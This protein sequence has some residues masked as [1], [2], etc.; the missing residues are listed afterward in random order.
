MITRSNPR[1]VHLQPV[2]VT[3]LAL[4]LSLL[5]VLL[6]R[7]SSDAQ[8]HLRLILS[9]VCLVVGVL[10]AR[11]SHKKGWSHTWILW[12]FYVFFAFQ[13][14]RAIDFF[15]FK[16][17]SATS[18]QFKRDAY[19]QD[20]IFSAGYL[21]LLLSYYW[22]CL[23][24]KN[25]VT[26]L[27]VLTWCAFL[28]AMISLPPLLLG[29]HN[30]MYDK[31]GLPNTGIFWPFTFHWRWVEEYFLP[32]FTHVNIFG[33]ILG[34]GFFPSLGLALYALYLRQT[35]AKGLSAASERRH[36]PQLPTII[37][38]LV[39]AAI[40]GGAILLL[41]S[42]G[43]MIAFFL[44]LFIFLV[45]HAIKFRSIQK[46]LVTGVL[47]VAIVGVGGWA[48]NLSKALKEVSTLASEVGGEGGSSSANK[49]GSQLARAIYDS[50]PLWGVGRNG[51]EK[52]AKSF[53][54]DYKEGQPLG[55][56]HYTPY[57]HY[58]KTLCEQGFGAYLYFLWLICWIL[59]SCWALYRTQSYFKFVI[60]LSLFCSVLTVL[61]HASF[62]FL[63]QYY[64]TSAFVYILMAMT[65]GVLS[66]HF[67]HES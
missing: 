54:R 36:L 45:I 29:G 7:E 33:D 62:G 6:G 12:L 25:V 17:I 21:S 47:L 50:N 53:D 37:L 63:M 46:T 39:R 58:L 9:A 38:C 3:L 22:G 34:F 4:F 31:P 5:F 10:C 41:F 2:S 8:V 16:E 61:I 13:I 11:H 19:G 20:L 14:G 27:N 30:P 49:K 51:Y 67:K 48:G 66:P 44:A 57:N 65:L 64:A 59:G 24:K 40:L 18:D 52:F 15:F 32:L 55:F 43:T 26:L 23:Q 42:R 35:T 1:K 60:G 56:S 28:L